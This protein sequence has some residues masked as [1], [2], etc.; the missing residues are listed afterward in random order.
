MKENEKATNNAGS[1]APTPI[2]ENR[3]MR[4]QNPA[5]N[6]LGGILRVGRTSF[7]EQLRVAEEAHMGK[8][9]QCLDQRICKETQARLREASLGSLA[10]LRESCVAG[11]RKEMET[12]SY[13]ALAKKI[14][15]SP[16]GLPNHDAAV[17]SERVFD[18]TQSFTPQ[19]QVP[20]GTEVL[21]DM[22][23][24]AVREEMREAK[25]E[26]QAQKKPKKSRETWH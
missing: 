13:A 12:H 17:G 20:S 15:T 6:D 2:P 25:K 1:K 5:G 26:S 24:E 16:L 3:Q 8:A 11:L 23:R 14:E 22:V 21:R 19:P 9:L 18:A 4:G 7:A 10:G